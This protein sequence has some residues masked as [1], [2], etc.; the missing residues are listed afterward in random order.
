MKKYLST[1]NTRSKW[2][3]EKRNIATGDVVLMVDPGDPRGHWPLVKFKR[4][5]LALTERSE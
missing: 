3:E 4:F 2:V 5:S 1:L